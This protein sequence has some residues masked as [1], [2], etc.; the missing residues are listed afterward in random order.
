M[1][2]FITYSAIKH[3]EKNDI[4][5]RN[6]ETSILLYIIGKFPYKRIFHKLK[7]RFVMGIFM[8]NYNEQ[9]RIL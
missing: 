7:K 9:K 1:N 2:V 5:Y 4:C 8:Y 6:R 3:S